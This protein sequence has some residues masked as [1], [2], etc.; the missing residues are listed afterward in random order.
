MTPKKKNLD[1]IDIE[2]LICSVFHL[3]YVNKQ[4]FMEAVE[5][6]KHF[7]LLYQATYQP[8]TDYLEAFKVHPKLSKAHNGETGTIQDWLQPRYQRSATCWNTL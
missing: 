2:K 8:N 6:K 5:T 7:Y 4:D 1:M 3:K